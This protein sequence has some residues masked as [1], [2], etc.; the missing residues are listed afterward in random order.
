MR[1]SVSHGQY[2]HIDVVVFH[3]IGSGPSNCSKPL[4]DY[5]N[6]AIYRGKSYEY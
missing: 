6:I 3:L 1:I 2:Y 4:I 5:R